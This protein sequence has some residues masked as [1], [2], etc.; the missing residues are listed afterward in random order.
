VVAVVVVAVVVAV[1]GIGAWWLWLRPG[2]S[3]GNGA[4]EATESVRSK[5]T[6]AGPE[7]TLPPVLD[8]APETSADSS[9]GSVVPETA[10]TDPGRAEPD[11]NP[12]GTDPGR[13]ESD[14]PLAEPDS[15][16]T[17]EMPDDA[18]GSDRW[19][20]R[21]RLDRTT[22][23][24]VNCDNRRVEVL[25]GLAPG[26][27]LVFECSRFLLIRASDGGAVMVGV[28]DEKLTPL[29]PDGVPAE[30][31]RIGPSRGEVDS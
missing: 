11:A 5:E 19:S 24:R 28:G 2:S 18:V 4:A 3:P 22:D 6:T 7:R 25:N 30:R 17:E 10:E 31:R 13:G 26:T 12:A 21:V 16:A 20:A 29:G 9:V 15:S 8:P 27:E 14:A 23:G 1:A